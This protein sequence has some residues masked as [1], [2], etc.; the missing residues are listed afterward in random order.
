MD[1]LTTNQCKKGMK[2]ELINPDKHYKIG[3][4]NPVKGSVFECAGTIVGYEAD[5]DWT[6]KYAISVEW[7]NGSTNS[8][9]NNELGLSKDNEQSLQTDNYH[10]IW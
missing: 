4:T 6:N 9:K 1:L 2:V 10:S 7:E 5:Y 8:Y 3:R